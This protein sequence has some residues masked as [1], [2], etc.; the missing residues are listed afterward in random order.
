MIG[1]TLLY[2]LSH[3]NCLRSWGGPQARTSF[4]PEG[5]S[6]RGEPKSLRSIRVQRRGLSSK[7]IF[8][9]VLLF[10]VVVSVIHDRL[11]HQGRTPGD[12]S[13]N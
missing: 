1:S 2:V 3:N 7:S 12:Y 11:P 10:R 4:T 13:L 8:V 5:E 6:E 9:I